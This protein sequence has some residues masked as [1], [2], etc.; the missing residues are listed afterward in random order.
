[1][2]INIKFQKRNKR[3]SSLVSQMTKRQLGVDSMPKCKALDPMPQEGY[4]RYL[5][6]KVNKVTDLAMNLNIAGQDYWLPK[7]QIKY[8]VHPTGIMFA[9]DVSRY[10]AK[11]KGLDS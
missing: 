3:S 4:A 5:V 2:R 6:K 9:V 8:G 10:I 11:E 1:M 7:S